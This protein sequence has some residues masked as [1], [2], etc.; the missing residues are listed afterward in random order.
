MFTEILEVAA[1][2]EDLES[3]LVFAGAIDV[4]TQ[5][6]ASTYHLDKLDLRPH[7]FEKH[8]IQDGRNINAGVQH[9]NRNSNAELIIFLELQHQIIAVVHRIVYQLASVGRIL[10][11]QFVEAI[12]NHLGVFMVV[13]KDDSF[14]ERFSSINTIT[15]LHQFL[16]NSAA[17]IL[18][19]QVFKNLISGNVEIGSRRI[20]L[21]IFI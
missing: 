17:G 18:V 21:Q 16:Q 15:P 10:R 7:L 2:V 13:G 4:L 19:E 11:V 6:G 1:I 20:F 5:S 8:Q 3:A 9:I 12:H 14:A